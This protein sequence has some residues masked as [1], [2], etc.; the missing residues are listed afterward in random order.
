M[1]EVKSTYK[2]EERQLSL[3]PKEGFLLL[4]LQT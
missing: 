4:D 3:G 1:K 2:F